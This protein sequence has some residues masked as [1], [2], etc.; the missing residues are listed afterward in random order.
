MGTTVPSWQ[1]PASSASLTYGV[2]STITNNTITT[3]SS[4]FTYQTSMSTPSLS[5]GTYLVTFSI[6]VDNTKD[7]ASVISIRL[8]DGTNYYATVASANAGAGGEVLVNG[9]STSAIITVAAN[10]VISGQ[11][12]GANYKA[13]ST[14][15]TLRAAGTGVTAKQNC[16]LSYVKIG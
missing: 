2:V 7:D 3:S 14:T 12:S 1:T 8:Y 13:N 9:A 5:A 10:G 6:I 11:W 15:F 4:S 16:L